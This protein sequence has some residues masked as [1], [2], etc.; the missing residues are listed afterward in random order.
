MLTAAISFPASIRAPFLQHFIRRACP[1]PVWAGRMVTMLHRQTVSRGHAVTC[2][3]R[4]RPSG[5]ERAPQS[6]ACGCV[7]VDPERERG[8]RA[9]VLGLGGHTPLP[10]HE[11]RF[12]RR[13]SK[14]VRASTDHIDQNAIG[15]RPDATCRVEDIPPDHYAVAKT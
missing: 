2:A 8:E 6:L 3:T 1:F 5:A 4:L 10:G 12:H 15:R 14:A 13:S 11:V 9:A 7:C